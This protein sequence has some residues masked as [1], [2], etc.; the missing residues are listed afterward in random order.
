MIK[1][2]IQFVLLSVLFINI[3]EAND[4]TIAI[5][6]DDMPFVGAGASQNDIK[7]GNDRFQYILNALIEQKVPATGFVIAGAIS[8]GQWQLLESFKSQGFMIG[9]HTYTH[10]NL[11]AIGA[12]KYIKDIAKADHRLLPLMTERKYFRYPYLAEGHGGARHQVQKYLAKN[13]YIIAPVTIDTK[14]FRF[15]MKFLAINWRVR[16]EHLEKIKQQYL[17]YIWKQTEQAERRAHGKEVKHILLL[18]ANLLNSHLIGDVIQLYKTH[19]YRFITLDE[20]LKP[21]K[22]EPQFV[23]S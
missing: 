11:D 5:T 23:E 21:R 15:N 19:G 7:R 18:H 16:A 17:S 3:A 10:E 14:D 9:N 12:E 13:Q 6:I 2:Y 20:A 1:K 22:S 8:K 4:K